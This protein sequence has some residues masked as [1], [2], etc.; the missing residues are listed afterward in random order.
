MPL[1][2]LY[3]GTRDGAAEIELF[4]PGSVSDVK[5]A[6]KMDSVEPVGSY[7]VRIY[8]NDGHSSGIYSFEHLRRICPCEVCV[9]A[10]A[11]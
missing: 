3:R 11:A 7:A 10:R 4:K 1:R 2:D 6:L 5:P 9:S 8:W